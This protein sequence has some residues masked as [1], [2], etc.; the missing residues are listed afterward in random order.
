MNIISSNTVPLPATSYEIFLAKRCPKCQQSA[1][2]RTLR[3]ECKLDWKKK[4]HFCH[5]C[6][7]FEYSRSAYW[8]LFTAIVKIIIKPPQSGTPQCKTYRYS[9][10]YHQVWAVAPRLWFQLLAKGLRECQYISSWSQLKSAGTIILFFDS[11]CVNS[12]C[13][14]FGMRATRW[15][16]FYLYSYFRYCVGKLT[17]SL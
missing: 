9:K 17:W 6:W 1:A 11:S 8:L 4:S 14:I 13:W 12:A 5:C 16:T 2:N 3:S 10:T 15:S 7:A